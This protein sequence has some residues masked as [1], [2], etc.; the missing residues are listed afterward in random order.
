MEKKMIKIFL[1]STYRDLKEE[2]QAIERQI[3]RLKQTFIGME[4][5]S[6][7]D[8]M[9]VERS[10][11]ALSRA[12]LVIFVV[13]HRYGTIDQ[14]SDISIVEVEY[15]KAWELRKPVMIYFRDE[16]VPI[17]P[18]NFEQAPAAQAKLLNFKTVLRTRHTVGTFKKH[19]QLAAA[20]C[21]DLANFLFEKGQWK[22]ALPLEI[23]NYRSFWNSIGETLTI[24]VEAG[25][26]HAPHPGE[27]EYAKNINGVLGL[28]AILPSLQKLGI[29]YTIGNSLDRFLDKRTNLLLDGSYTGNKVT[30]E[31]VNH[32]SV[33][34]KLVFMSNNSENR[35]TRWVEKKGTGVKYGTEYEKGKVM[36]P[37][38]P[39]KQIAYDYGFLARIKNPFDISKMCLI[40][41]GNH[42]AGTYAC[43][44]VLSS[45][46]LLNSI[47]DRVGQSDFQAIIGVHLLGLFHFEIPEIKEIVCVE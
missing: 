7:S 47:I 12:D 33:K 27:L 40:A 11:R 26:R 8:E 23:K 22:D 32:Q 20:V 35:F 2:R 24:V 36:Y 43:M 42:G 30:D 19:D 3:N 41:S 21:V 10:L 6:A 14:D 38:G 5:F 37:G 28:S 1:S 44:K 18:E 45:P 29:D 31:V 39:K 25:K 16:S 46:R 13:A 15:N 34:E 4:Y 9:P 17:L